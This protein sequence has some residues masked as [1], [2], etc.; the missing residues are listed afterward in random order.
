MNAYL[1]KT[2]GEDDNYVICYCRAKSG[3][4]ALAIGCSL[5]P[6]PEERTISDYSATRC[7]ALEDHNIDVIELG[8]IKS[9]DIELLSKL[10]LTDG[11]NYFFSSREDRDESLKEI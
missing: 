11:N 7:Q 1:V 10:G 5:D 8:N 2:I 3:L 6:S 9:K 4:D